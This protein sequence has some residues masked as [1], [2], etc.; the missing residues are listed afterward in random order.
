MTWGTNAVGKAC[1]GDGDTF[2][3]FLTIS[4]CFVVAVFLKTRLRDKET[5]KLPPHQNK[6]VIRNQNV[7]F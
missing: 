3:P 7:F 6:L 5:P 4:E 1:V 2:V